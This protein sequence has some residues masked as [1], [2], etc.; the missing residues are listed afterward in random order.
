MAQIENRETGNLHKK[1]L[2]GERVKRH[3]LVSCAATHFPTPFHAR[4]VSRS[5]II[6]IRFDGRKARD[7]EAE[8]NERKKEEAGRERE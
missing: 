7:G 1:C 8:R 4:P 3:K 2:W 6:Q 5:V